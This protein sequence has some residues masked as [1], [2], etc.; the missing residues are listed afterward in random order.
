MLSRFLK[1][2]DKY[3]ETTL[4]DFTIKDNEVWKGKL[5]FW[6]F[7]GDDKKEFES[8]NNK[9]KADLLNGMWNFYMDMQD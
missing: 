1:Y 3:S 7:E 8:A 6:N 2:K 4:Q 5:H 9:A